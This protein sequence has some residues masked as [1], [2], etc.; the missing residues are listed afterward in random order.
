MKSQRRAWH[1]KISSDDEAGEGVQ[2]SQKSVSMWGEED[3]Y[4]WAIESSPHGT[5][6]QVKASCGAP[7]TGH[8]WSTIFYK[9]SSKE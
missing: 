7:Q 2:G 8:A 1:E 3:F 6:K 5:E 9:Y 4:K